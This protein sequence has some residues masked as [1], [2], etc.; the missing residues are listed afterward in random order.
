MTVSAHATAVLAVGSTYTWD[1]TLLHRAWGVPGCNTATLIVQGS[2]V[3]RRTTVLVDAERC[4]YPP[5]TRPQLRQL[6]VDYVDQALARLATHEP[7][8]TWYSDLDRQLTSDS[9]LTS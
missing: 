8:A 5:P 3:R 1:A 4:A 7:D 2:P 6:E 9:C